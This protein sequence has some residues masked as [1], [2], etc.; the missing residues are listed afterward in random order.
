MSAGRTDEL[1][2]VVTDWPAAWQQPGLFALGLTGVGMT[3][4]AAADT[5]LAGLLDPVADVAEGVQRLIDSEELRPARTLLERTGT[6]LTEEQRTELAD[7]IT[8]AAAAARTARQPRAHRLATR[9]RALKLPA[10]EEY[11]S[12]LASDS[13]READ[14]AL[15]EWEEALDGEA[16]KRRTAIEKHFAGLHRDRIAIARACLKSGEYAVAEHVVTQTEHEQGWL[17]PASVSRPPRWPYRHSYDRVVEWFLGKAAAPADFAEHRPAPSDEQAWALVTALQDAY[18]E[19][20]QNSA[21]VLADA[22]GHLIQDAPTI[23][24]VRPSDNGG[25]TVELSCFV[26]ARLPWLAPSWRTTLHIG[27]RLPEPGAE[28]LL[29]LPTSVDRPVLPQGVAVVEPHLLFSLLEPDGEGRSYPT[30]W[31]RMNMLRHVC[32]QLPFDQVVNLA[33]QDLG[34]E[35]GIRASLLWLFDVLGLC[36]APEVA[37]MVLFY[38]AAVPA[39]LEAMLRE[40]SRPRRPRDLVHE[41]LSRLR[42]DPDATRAVRAAVFA[43]LNDDMPAR[44]VCGALLGAA[45]RLGTDRVSIRRLDAE[46]DDLTMLLMEEYEREGER[47]RNLALERIDIDNTLTRVENAGLAER[48]GDDVVLPGAGLVSLIAGDEAIADTVRVLRRLHENLDEAEELARLLLLSRTERQNKHVKKGFLYAL[49]QLRGRQAVTG[50]PVE[51]RAIED[52]ITALDE[53]V[54]DC[55]AIESG[56]VEHAVRTTTFDFVG[57]ARSLMQAQR[58]T[59]RVEVEVVDR[60]EGD[61]D[62]T[63]RRLLVQLTLSDLILNATQAMDEVKSPRRA[64]RITVRHQDTATERFLVADVEDSGPGFGNTD[65]TEL[66]R[67]RKAN[68]MP[69]GEGLQHALRALEACRGKLE[70][71]QGNSPDLGGAHLRVWLPLAM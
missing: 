34:D 66:D 22:F 17:G 59:G 15:D 33:E 20:N 53:L 28:P 38:T 6:S 16:A 24:R 49:D 43:P 67:V 46:L 2:V 29:W 8:R 51:R 25:F 63:A 64:V 55:T 70:R 13:G 58:P 50:D 23:H 36:A 62:V 44:V 18:A 7:R 19:L 52:Q 11:W 4:T 48:R 35:A 1:A 56:D 68:G 65:R 3:A 57:L 27:T 12:L 42:N 47:P 10:D 60:T 40:L 26:D 14:G 39:A 54:A 5:V 31:R 37:D 32:A 69:G 71:I 41:D 45:A 30:Q 61:G 9:A 21:R